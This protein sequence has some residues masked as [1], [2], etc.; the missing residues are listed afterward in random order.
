[1]SEIISNFFFKVDD[2]DQSLKRHNWSEMHLFNLSY[3]SSCEA[4][5]PP[6]IALPPSLFIK[7]LDHLEVLDWLRSLPDDQDFS[8]GIEMAMGLGEMECPPELW[9]QEPG[10]PGRVNEQILSMAQSV[11][12]YL[13]SLIFRSSEQFVDLRQMVDLCLKKF[14]P[15]NVSLLTHLENCGKYLKHLKILLTSGCNSIEDR[16]LNLLKPSSGARWICEYSKKCQEG[17][18]QVQHDAGFELSL[19]VSHVLRLEYFVFQKEDGKRSLSLSDIEDFQSALLTRTD[20]SDLMHSKI[21]DFIQCFGWIK[22]YAQTLVSLHSVGHFQ[23]S[24]F[25]ESF[26]FERDVEK[27]HSA[28][29]DAQK[30]LEEWETLLESVRNRFPTI[31]Y[32]GAKILR[33]LTESLYNRC[34]GKQ[35]SITFLPVV[36]NLVNLINPDIAADLS[37]IACLEEQLCHQWTELTRE[38]ET[39]QKEGEEK[40]HRGEKK[41]EEEE[42]DN[43]REA[44]GFKEEE[45]FQY[46]PRQIT[47]EEELEC[48]CKVIEGSLSP[49]RARIRLCHFPPPSSTIP[50]LNEDPLV[51]AAE[52][53]SMSTSTI[54]SPANQN[55]VPSPSLV[56]TSSFTPVI[57][58][59]VSLKEGE[60]GWVSLICSQSPRSV[61]CELLSVYFQLGRMPER[62]LVLVCSKDTSWED[63]S[64]LLFRWRLQKKQKSN[65]QDELIEGEG[66]ISDSELEGDMTELFCLVGP[67]LLSGEV[68]SRAI[69]SIR[70]ASDVCCPLL[71]LCTS[72]AQGGFAS[73][74]ATKR[75]SSF[76]RPLSDVRKVMSEMYPDSLRT[77]TSI[78]P[79]AGKTFQVRVQTN[80]TR[81]YCCIPATDLQQFVSSMISKGVSFRN[82]ANL[83]KNENF[84]FHIDVYDTVGPDL[85]KILFDLVFFHGLC[86]FGSGLLFSLLSFAFFIE[87][88]TGPI[89]E[90]LMV[91]FLFPLERV[92]ASPKSF[93]P[94]REM[95][96]AG[97]GK[98]EF[99]AKR[100]DGTQLRKKDEGIRSA[101][102][103]DRIQYVCTA[104]DIMQRNND[105]FPYLFETNV[106]EKEVG[107]LS[108]SL[109]NSYS[110]TGIEVPEDEIPG[111]TCF[112]LL[113]KASGLPSNHPSLWCLWA[114]VNMVY[115]QLRDMHYPDSPLND[116]CMPVFQDTETAAMGVDSSWRESAETKEAIKGEIINFLL[117]TAREF[118][119]RQSLEMNESEELGLAVFGFS[120]SVYNGRWDKMPYQNDGH[121]VYWKGGG[122]SGNEIENL[123]LYYRAQS[124]Q[125]VIDDIICNSGAAWA[126]CSGSQLNGF[127]KS[128]SNWNTDYSARR[129]AD[130]QMTPRGYDGKGLLVSGFRSWEVDG[131][132]YLQPPFDDINGY[133]H[134]IK[135]DGTR[136]HIFYADDLM[137]HICPKCNVDEGSYGKTEDLLGYWSYLPR[138]ISEN[139]RV[140]PITAGNEVKELL[141]KE[142]EGEEEEIFQNEGRQADGL[143]EE[144]VRMEKKEGKSAIE[145]YLAVETLYE[146]T[147]KWNDSNHQ[148]LLF[149][150]LNHVVRFLSRDPEKMRNEMHPSLLDFLEE[151]GFNMNESLDDLSDRSLLFFHFKFARY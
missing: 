53:L 56:A 129:R 149:S 145:E 13:H 76:P 7:I 94:S 18:D 147:L 126:Y 82:S 81:Q 5:P 112:N 91:P 86:D 66:N 32:Y 84:S 88:P 131:W 58:E 45:P 102:A 62:K 132:Y 73:Y 29:N 49:I 41:E 113:V 146:K 138:D 68:Q 95:L 51:E 148:C 48:C 11:R 46:V 97:M 93:C 16:L 80:E 30:L 79:G 98:K 134:Y 70:K 128:G 105:R 1:M 90:Q 119:T 116:I 42:E 75:I 137:W 135:L 36:V 115:W 60:D 3:F 15:F 52:F 55:P 104:L 133:P 108:E 33:Y 122:R 72:N 140:M 151:N 40:V 110:L 23:F 107:E 120:K 26:P 143:F 111:P 114:F 20:T 99:F 74:F 44:L 65:R 47:L 124:D 106:E 50:S 34:L 8:R 17:D 61:Y 12:T 87:I 59:T 89:K 144:P 123:Y 125:W 31:N 57:E 21:S 77:F 43:L 38:R 39:H 24:S 10:Q 100:Y 103:F 9:L 35:S 92:I 101:H 121:P 6:L 19:D 139:V 96:C 117:R 28:A 14:G 83:F 150:N 54:S 142:E 136:R 25:R 69:A 4:I 85:D 141:E 27:V 71:L 2:L 64:L 109:R 37:I 127:W 130:E 118:A 22:Q 67:D 78:F 63:V